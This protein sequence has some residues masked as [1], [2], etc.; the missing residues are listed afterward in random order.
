LTSVASAP[1]PVTPAAGKN[2]LT[3]I[4]LLLLD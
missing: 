1:Q 2:S 4:L 3:P